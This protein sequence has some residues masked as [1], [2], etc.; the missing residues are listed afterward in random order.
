MR[1]VPVIFS[2]I[3][4]LAQQPSIAVVEKKAGTVGFYTADGKRVSEVKVGSFPHET[5]FSPDRRFLYVTDNGLLWMTDPG[6]GFNTISIIDLTTRKKTAAIDLGNYRRPHGIAVVEKT[7]QIV[8][9]IENPDGLLLVDPGARKVVRKYDVKGKSPH[10]VTLGPGAQVAYVSN[11]NSGGVAALNLASG[12]VEKFIP[13]GK[14][15]QGG[16]LTRDGKILYI[17]N[18]ESNTI[19]IIDTSKN[20]V[21]GE[22]KTGEQPG[23]VELTPDEKFLVYNLQRGEGCGIADPKTRKQVAEIHVP[24]KPL[25][26]SLSRDG[27]TAYLGLMDSDTVAV[28][29]VPERKVIRVIPT[30]K[31]AGPDT[32]TPL[33]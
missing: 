22:I 27:R 3:S 11:S 21:I 9:T 29:S 19:S 1:L 30:P 24:G 2:A 23:R 33:G 5:A 12:N 4:L 13:T 14:N 15:P 18:G 25:S 28:V 26:V 20:E 8:T 16:V 10:M 32:V 7:G 6:E 31:G 17:A